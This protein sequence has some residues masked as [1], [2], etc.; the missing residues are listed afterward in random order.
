MGKNGNPHTHGQDYVEGNP[1]FENIT[2][3]EETRE[4][5]INAGY[6]DARNLKTKET[7]ETD[8]GEF[9]ADHV[10]EWH[11]AKDAGGNQLYPFKTELLQ[12]DKEGK[13]QCIDLL[14]VLEKY[15]KM[16]V[17]Q[18]STNCEKFF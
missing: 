14:D 16:T 5:L 3:D 18:I 13:P 1:T 7:C 11:P 6:P 4:A 2:L 8:L 10:K 15:T 9:F 17:P 12:Q